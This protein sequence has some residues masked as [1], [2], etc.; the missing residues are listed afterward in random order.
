MFL[1]GLQEEDRN[2]KG[3]FTYNGEVRIRIEH[4]T[5]SPYI[6]LHAGNTIGY[7][8]NDV[9]LHYRDQENEKWIHYE[10]SFEHFHQKEY[11]IIK[12]QGQQWTVGFE[13]QILIR[14]SNWI[15][16][17][18]YGLFE[19]WY[20]DPDTNQRRWLAATQF[21]RVNICLYWQLVPKLFKYS[22]V[23]K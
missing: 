2:D 9:E 11:L 19:S 3:Y 18:G 22:L 13:Y 4:N 15:S 1:D 17:S 14:F 23:P 16:K 21:Q 5:G 12:N 7:S 10:N 8:I 20:L 6:V